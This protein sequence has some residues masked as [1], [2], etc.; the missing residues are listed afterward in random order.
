MRNREEKK[1]PNVENLKWRTSFPDRNIGFHLV[2]ETWK[3][4]EEKKI[5]NINENY[6]HYV[7]FLLFYISL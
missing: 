2:R 1:L 5:R 4:F 6:K 3:V 7:L